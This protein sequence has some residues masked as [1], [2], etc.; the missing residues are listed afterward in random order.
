MIADFHARAIAETRGGHLVGVVGRSAE[1]AREFAERHGAP[2]WTT[3]LSELLARPD[4]QVVCVTTPNGAHLGPAIAAA[5]AGKHLV[6]EKPIEI[7]LDRLDE[8]LRVVRETGVTLA[9]IFQGRFGEGA[10]TV[11]AAVEAGRFGRLSLC[12]AYVKWLRT[13]DY[14]RNS[15]HGKYALDGGGVYM[16]QA[17]HGIDLLQWLA[18]M[19]TEVFAY[20]TRC[21]HQD[22]EGE[23]TA[24]ATLRFANGALGVIEASTACHPGWSRCIELCGENGSVRLEDDRITRW[25]FRERLPGDEVVVAAG[26]TDALGSG[27]AAPNA[28]SHDGHRRQIQDLIDALRE[29]RP[30]AI[31]GPEARKAVALICALYDSAQRNAPVRV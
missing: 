4:L 28:I 18:G 8:V 15:W 1:K 26:A 17:I 2:F 23:D 24:A 5:R 27:A 31:D 22:I 19:P 21:V 6:V 25:D 16:N 20:A 14:Y 10:R 30:L 13:P 7:T 9:P 3:E 29:K 12:S 11:K